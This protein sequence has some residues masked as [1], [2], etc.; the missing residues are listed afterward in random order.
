MVVFGLFHGIVFLPVLL[1]WVG[2]AAYDLQENALGEE[3]DSSPEA[4][5]KEFK[6]GKISPQ[7]G[8]I[9]M[10]E[11]SSEKPQIKGFVNEG[12]DHDEDEV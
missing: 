12:M 7:P 10:V 11:T 2:P 1:S 6:N 4:P 8:D 3:K 9:V 5:E